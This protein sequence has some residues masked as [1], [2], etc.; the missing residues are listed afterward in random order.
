M[1]DIFKQIK[2]LSK[3]LNM[4][5]IFIFIIV[6]QTRVHSDVTSMQDCMRKNAKNALGTREKRHLAWI[7]PKSVP[8]IK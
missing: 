3:Y 8:L 1:R 4:V 5:I 6:C 7:K 2:T